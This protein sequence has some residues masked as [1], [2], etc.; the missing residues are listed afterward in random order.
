MATQ[1]D[2]WE[3]VKA[4]LA[5]ALQEDAGTRSPFLKERCPDASVC[6]EM[7]RLLPEHDQTAS[8]FLPT[9]LPA[10]SLNDFIPEPAARNQQLSVSQVL[11]G[12]FRIVR[13]I[14]GGSMGEVY[15][16]EDQQLRERLA[17]KTPRDFAP[18]LSTAC[19]AVILRGLAR[20]P[21]ERRVRVMFGNDPS[22]LIRRQ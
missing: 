20:D 3:A 15:E 8:S 6:A 1:Q 16:A 9:E 19:E 10:V 17:V 18:D 13:W 14:A 7:E 11:A 12:R 4:L 2:N 5:A 22:L 21:A